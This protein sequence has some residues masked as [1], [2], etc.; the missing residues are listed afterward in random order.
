MA[1]PLKD[2]DILW[3]SGVLALGFAILIFAYVRL[4]VA[5]ETLVAIES[6]APLAIRRVHV[7][8]S[9]RHSSGYFVQRIDVVLP[10]SARP[11]TV[12]PVQAILI[13]EIEDLRYGTVRFA[14][15]PAAR[16]IY[17]AAIGDRL[18]LTYAAA[19][20]ERRQS[21]LITF[22]GGLFCIGVGAL[23]LS[24]LWWPGDKT[25]RPPPA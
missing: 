16:L 6:E 18:L 5:R 2:T 20:K 19:I 17:E 8:T 21:V 10:G 24:P 3:W 11:V 9:G 23:G 25:P 15:D 1:E 12:S 13:P 4:P 14:I 7:D 22:L